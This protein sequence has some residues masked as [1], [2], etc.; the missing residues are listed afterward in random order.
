MSNIEMHSANAILAISSLDRY[1]TS[2]NEIVTNI[3]A[4]WLLSDPFKM[5]VTEGSPVLG[6][7]LIEIGN[8]FPNPPPGSKVLILD[9][10]N[11]GPSPIITINFPVTSNSNGDQVLVQVF[12]IGS[13]SQP[14]S[15]IILGQYRNLG[16]DE[17]GSPCNNFIISSPGALIYGYINRIVV[18]QIQLQYNIPTICFNRNDKIVITWLESG[19]FIN[20]AITIPFG[21]Y[22]PGE[23]EAATQA[24]IN[25]NA[26]FAPLQLTVAYNELNGFTFTSG[27]N[28][29]FGFASPERLLE[30]NYSQRE[31]DRILKTYRVYGMTF[32]NSELNE[33]D[34]QISFNYP[35]FLY[36]PYI[37]IFSDVLTNY[38]SMKDTNTSV[39]KPK[40]LIARIYL[41][42]VSSPVI[43]TG[44][45]ALGSAPFVMTSDLNSPKVIEWTPDVA[46]PSID[47]QLRD[48]YGELIPGDV[49]KYPSEFQMTLLCLES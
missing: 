43:Q 11:S 15:N 3:E 16:P 23:L 31:I 40:G 38:Q 39:A 10:D 9:I 8:G 5:I 27:S 42:G 7:Q 17:G 35:N 20:G 2:R 26:T 46:V 34:V 24:L 28:T 47:F 12:N 4:Y 29:D 18:S 41:S 32:D 14:V 1:T 45:M 22:T 25:A 19:N 37:D 21:F 33:D 44:L 6:A 48:C 30:F 36:T 49:E 13:A